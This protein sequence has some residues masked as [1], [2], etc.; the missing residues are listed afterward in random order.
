MPLLPVNGVRLHVEDKGTGD[1]IVFVHEFGGDWRSWRPQIRHFSRNHRCVAY[2]ARGYPPSEVPDDEGAY[3][4]DV[5]TADL[6]GVLDALGI[7]KAVVVGCSMGAYTALM[8]AIRRPERVSAVV[9]ASGG[10]GAATTQEQREAFKR[11]SLARA[12]R[13]LA[14]GTANLPEFAAGPARVQLKRKNPGGFAE[15]EKQLGQHSAK[16]S[17][18]TLRRV[19]T[20]RAPLY[21]Y[22]RE[23]GALA[24]PVLLV[25]GDEDEAC[26]DVN[27]WLKRTIPA[28][29]L[30]IL[31]RTGHLVNLEEPPVFNRIVD[32]FLASVAR[33]DWPARKLAA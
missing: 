19:Q 33:N 12:E 3:G 21:D 13:M 24:A 1:P 9:A 2:N 28:A 14:A 7:A 30:S 27:G 26:L 32:S 29:G 16:G 17:A 8:L 18:Y 25:V 10:S 11:D 31:P 15:F 23:L 6:A 20:L 22:K 4:Q 5:A